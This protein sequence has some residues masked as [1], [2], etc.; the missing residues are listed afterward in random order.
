MEYKDYYQI[1]GVSKNADEQTIKRAYRDLA[2]KYHPDKNPSPEA[3][4]RFKEINEAYEVL[5]DKTKRAKYD[6]LGQ[7]YRNWERTTSQPG[8]F[9]WSQWT[10]ASPGGGVRVEM[11]DLDDLFGGGGFSDFFNAIFGGMAAGARGRTAARRARSLEQ[12][13]E[14]SLQEAFTG[15]TRLLQQDGKRYEIDIPAG[16]RTGTKVR[17][18]GKGEQVPGQAPGDLYLVVEVK[19]EPGIVRRGDNLH[20]E[21]TVDLY[22]AVLGGEV[23]VDAL[24]KSVMLKIPPGS[25]PEQVFKLKNRGMPHLQQ[26]SQR[27]DMYV[28]LKV[29]LPEKLNKEQRELYKKLAEMS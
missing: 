26:P 12:A 27:G 20:L 18:T 4:E 10:T 8:G 15:T 24:G 6:R 7:S 1:L 22:T 5:G 25:Q 9:D 17:L 29:Q 3:E 16:A 23:K 14:I 21:V 28:K 19:P 11:G 2:L 13:V